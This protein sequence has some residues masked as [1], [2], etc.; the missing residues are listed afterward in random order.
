M[1][2]LSKVIIAIL[3]AADVV[4]SMFIPISLAL[5]I[6]ILVDL[7]TFNVWALLSIGFLSTIYR[8]IKFWVVK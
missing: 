5:M 3:G 2:N 7:S 6:V 8:A 1:N 4:F